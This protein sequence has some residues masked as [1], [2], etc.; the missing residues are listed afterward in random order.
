MFEKDDTNIV[1]FTSSFFKVGAPKIK[2][3]PRKKLPLISTNNRSREKIV[4]DY[5]EQKEIYCNYPTLYEK[6]ADINFL[7]V[8]I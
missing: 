6:K 3:Q 5:E 2:N 8:F 4:E 7:D 1:S